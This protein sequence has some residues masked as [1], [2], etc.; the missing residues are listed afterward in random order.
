MTAA[1]EALR[2][3][4]GAVV[5]GV[6]AA[7]WSGSEAAVAVAATAWWWRSSGGD[8]AVAAWRQELGAATVLA[9][10]QRW[11]QGGIALIQAWIDL[12]VF[13]CQRGSSPHLYNV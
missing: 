6:T 10:R 1:A 4:L 9:R 5:A 7:W 8:A 2:R 3:Q 12:M 11:R 13:F